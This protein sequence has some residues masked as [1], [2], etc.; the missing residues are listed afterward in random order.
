MFSGALISICGLPG[1]VEPVLF[2][3]TDFTA[4]DGL[5]SGLLGYVFAV[6]S[7]ERG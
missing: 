2:F 7:G 5:L 6:G 1:L 4:A 3:P